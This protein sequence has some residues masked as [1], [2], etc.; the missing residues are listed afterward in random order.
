[1]QPEHIIFEFYFCIL[2][3]KAMKLDTVSKLTLIGVY[4]M[5]NT[6]AATMAR[7][8]LD[9]SK[10][11]PETLADVFGQAA[12][13]DLAGFAARNQITWLLSNIARDSHDAKEVQKHLAKTAAHGLSMTGVDIRKAYDDFL[14]DMIGALKNP[15]PLKN[16]QAADHFG[17]GAPE[18]ATIK[19]ALEQ[20]GFGFEGN[21][22]AS[23]PAPP[24][25]QAYRQ[26]R[27]LRA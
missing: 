4:A 22:I 26:N 15:S 6:I 14:T 7:D 17:I 11:S 18:L 13:K 24:P 9:R 23:L 5:Q 19:T 3:A 2:K 12:A 27:A 8:D 16:A 25:A 20:A 10:A 21:T 1:M